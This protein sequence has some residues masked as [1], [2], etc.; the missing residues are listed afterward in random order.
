[1][2]PAWYVVARPGQR[3]CTRLW[4]HGAR[5]PSHPASPWSQPGQDRELGWGH[6]YTQPWGVQGNGV[7]CLHTNTLTTCTQSAGFTGAPRGRQ[8]HPLLQL[9]SLDLRAAPRFPQS[10]SW[11]AVKLGFVSPDKAPWFSAP[12]A[13]TLGPQTLPLTIHQGTQAT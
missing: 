8:H 4:E 6:K 11:S 5:C 1:M 13:V 9:G 3:G 10:P 12:D 7:P 2:L